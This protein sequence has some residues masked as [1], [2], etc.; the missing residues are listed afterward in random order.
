MEFTPLVTETWNSVWTIIFILINCTTFNLIYFLLHFARSSLFKFNLISLN[1]QIKPTTF[2]TYLRFLPSHLHSHSIR[3]YA[4]KRH[5]RGWCNRNNGNLKS[6][7]MKH[8]CSKYNDKSN[9]IHI[10]RNYALIPSETKTLRRWHAETKTA[11]SIQYN[12]NLITLR[13][14]TLL[15]LKLVFSFLSYT[16][17]FHFN[18]LLLIA[19]IA[20]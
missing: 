17:W 15:N 8:D 3:S 6:E 1:N 14:T 11:T 10:L 12:F 2:C 20:H 16:K 13:N 18:Q 5:C 7:L 19:V 9:S 4:T